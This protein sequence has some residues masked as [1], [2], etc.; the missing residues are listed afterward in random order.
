MKIRKLIEK[1]NEIAENHPE[2][3][4]LKKPLM[5]GGLPEEPDPT[6]AESV[7]EVIYLTDEPYYLKI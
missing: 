3:E 7:G 4:V 6:I 1:L 2:V 5:P